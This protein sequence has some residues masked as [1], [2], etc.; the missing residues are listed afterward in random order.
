[1]AIA[2]Y[3]L[4]VFSILGYLAAMICYAAQYAFG[5]RGPV[6][7]AAAR[8]A[9]A[10]ALAGARAGTDTATDTATDTGTDTA[11]D[12]A[13]DTGTDTVTGTGTGTGRTSPLDRVALGT[14][15]VAAALH[16]AA[17]ITRG[18]AATRAPWGD[19]YEFL[20]S[21]TLIGVAV[22]LYIVVR[23][24]RVRH[25][26]LY[27]ALANLILL[28]LAWLLY[29]PV[30][31]LV[32]ALDSAWFIIHVAAAALASGI[33]II[34]FV[35]AVMY[36]I[37]AGY[38]RGARRFPY[39]LGSQVPDA[40]AVERLTFKLI[41][42]A[43]PIWTFAVI[44]GAIWAEASWGRYWA[45]DPKEVWAFISWVVYAGYLHARAT[46]SVKRTVAAWLAVL[47]FLTVMMNLFGV[48]LLF[49]SLHS[50]A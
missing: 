29:S 32:P 26:S 45:W 36:L 12:T 18:V 16:L 35:T 6:A 33:F 10:P 2:S 43:F 7:R 37:R 14:L 13:T 20:L 28:G 34:G 25:V 30:E 46:P 17:V 23:Y 22:W 5:N 47:G 42:F 31:P 27:V 41:A 44:A 11:T 9:H 38:E 40:D 49:D 24:P 4:L 50:Y 19:M 39:P 21:T 48:N 1:M 8:S 3:L 15:L